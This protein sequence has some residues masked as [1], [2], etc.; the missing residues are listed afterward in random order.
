MACFDSSRLAPYAVLAAGVLVFFRRVLFSGRYIIPFDLPGYHLPLA[1]YAA[2]SLGAG[3][4]PLWDPYSY[5]GVPFYANLQAQLFYPPAWVV[6]ALANFVGLDSLLRLL[7]WEIAAHVFLGGLGTY[8]LVRRLGADRAAALFAGI[9]YE[10]GGY[11]A[12]QAQHL[13]AMCGAAWLPLAWLGVL[14]LAEAP[15]R[16]RT[17]VLGVVFAMAILAGFPTVTMV[18]FATSWALAA[19]RLAPLGAWFRVAAASAG[20]LLVAAVQLLP[21]RELVPLSQA[22]LRSKWTDDAGGIPWQGLVSLV[23]PNHYDLFDPARYTLPWNPTFLYLYC[24]LAAVVLAV[25]ALARRDRHSA[26]FA[27]VTVAAGLAMMGGTTTPGRIALGWLPA[28]LKSPLYPEFFSAA[29][30]LGLASLAGLGAARW[31]TRRGPAWGAA[32]VL[33]T[34]ADL[35]WTG[36]NRF[37]NTMPAAE[38][39]LITAR[40]FEGSPETLAGVRSLVHQTEPPARIDVRNDSVGWAHQAPAIR[41]PTANGNDP[42]VLMRLLAVRRIFAPGNEWERFHQVSVLDSPVLDLLNVRYLL[43][44]APDSGPGIQHPK[45]RLAASLPGH[46][47]F[48]NTAVLPR[49]YL[50]GRTRRAGSPEEALEFLRSAGFD[51]RREAV[52]EGAEA[53]SGGAEGT[54]RVLGY[55]AERVTLESESEA[56][57]F[58]VSSE[59]WYPGWRATVD[60]RERPLVMTNGAFRGLALEAGRHRIEM[61]FAPG[62][63]WWGAGLSAAGWV[64]VG[65]VI[66]RRK[67]S[68]VRPS[69]H[70]QAAARLGPGHGRG[71]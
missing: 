1:H 25:A 58:L 35:V 67:R 60:G 15:D 2:G 57:S 11:F 14:K 26:T 46:Q 50:V 9:V 52:V 36:S 39:A 32:L 49:F 7:E 40:S 51:P 45:F 62:I 6:F 59:T 64:L 54:V 22:S 8:W 18:V 21:T 12:A 24:G 10:L 56:R 65:L 16:R 42:L 53:L 66:G 70:Q 68:L 41:V 37:W 34:L 48:E 71:A 55:S 19:V 44:Y 63:L 47:V 13:G 69:L 38:A 17:A 23:A 5:C 28:G 33:A 27:L 29:F 4:L 30:V 3:R 20:S 31:V 61:R 43:T